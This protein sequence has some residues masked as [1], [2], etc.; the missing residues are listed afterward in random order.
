MPLFL[1]SLQKT[2]LFFICPA[3]NFVILS[4]PL[5]GNNYQLFLPL[6]KTLSF[7]CIT[8]ISCRKYFPSIHTST[9]EKHSPLI[10]TSLAENSVLFFLPLLQKTFFLPLLQKNGPS[11]PDSHTKH[12]ILIL[13]NPEKIYLTCSKH[14]SL[15]KKFVLFFLPLLQK[16]LAFFSCLSCRKH[17]PLIPASPAKNSVL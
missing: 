13:T 5:L 3:E 17:F 16:T 11:I 7:Y 2:L 1:S 12:C 4:L 6:H 10:P 15:A 9:A 8:A 14:A